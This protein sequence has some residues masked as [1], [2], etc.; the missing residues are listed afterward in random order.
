M[1]G[2]ASTLYLKLFLLFVICF[3]VVVTKRTILRA[4]PYKEHLIGRHRSRIASKE[5]ISVNL[6]HYK[7]LRSATLDT[8]VVN[9]A[10]VPEFPLTWVCKI[11]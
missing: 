8:W 4:H 3:P 6:I 5:A 2:C 11:K 1:G 10:G 7:P 9:Y